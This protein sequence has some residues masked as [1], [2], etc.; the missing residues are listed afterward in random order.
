MN[1]ILRRI[2]II[3]SIRRFPAWYMGRNPDK[4]ITCAIYATDF[5]GDFGRDVSKVRRGSF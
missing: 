4:Q 5:A 2:S 1:P 3:L